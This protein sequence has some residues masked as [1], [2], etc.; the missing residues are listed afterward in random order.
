MGRKRKTGKN[1]TADQGSC[2]IYQHTPA[3]PAPFI[4]GAKDPTGFWGKERFKDFTKNAVK[5][6]DLSVGI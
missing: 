5:S 4:G 2:K 3:S 6:P 1:K